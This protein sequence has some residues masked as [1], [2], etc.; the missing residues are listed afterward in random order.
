MCAQRQQQGLAALLFS[1]SPGISQS[2]P[3]QTQKV[4]VQN[5]LETICYQRQSV[6][7][8]SLP[9]AKSVDFRQIW[10]IGN[11]PSTIPIQVS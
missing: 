11:L 1:A 2:D 5:L 6:P 7:W 9:S 4:S 3:S 10:M 8:G